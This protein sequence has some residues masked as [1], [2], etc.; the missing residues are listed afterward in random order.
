MVHAIDEDWALSLVGLPMK[1]EGRWWPGKHDGS[2][3]HHGKIAAINF[4]PTDE[5][6]KRTTAFFQLQLDQEDWTYGMLYDAVLQ[7][8]CGKGKH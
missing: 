7:Y 4:N 3:M 2:T 6:G 8:L 5:K 1:V